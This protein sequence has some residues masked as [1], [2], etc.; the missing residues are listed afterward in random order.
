[1]ASGGGPTGGR[2]QSLCLERRS[3]TMHTQMPFARFLL[4]VAALGALLVTTSVQAQV[5]CPLTQTPFASYVAKFVCGPLGTY[6]DVVKGRYATTINV[7]NPQLGLEVQFCKKAV[8]ALPERSAFGTISHESIPL[9]AYESTYGSW[10][11]PETRRSRP[12]CAPT[13]P[14]SGDISSGTRQTSA[15]LGSVAP[16]F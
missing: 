10:R 11:P 7:H 16:L 2:Y 15:P 13:G 3:T 14:L 5:A 1:R 4:L 6:A 8:I 12:Q 9:L